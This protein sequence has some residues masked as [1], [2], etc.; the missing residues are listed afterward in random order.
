[1]DVELLQACRVVHLCRNQVR[2]HTEVKQPRPEPQR[3]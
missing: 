2:E 3:H 1:M